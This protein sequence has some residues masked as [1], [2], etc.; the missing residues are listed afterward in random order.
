[1]AAKNRDGR[2]SARTDNSEP[3][4]TAG[5]AGGR[6]LFAASPE[7]VLVRTKVLLKIS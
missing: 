1:M 3:C 6:C 5:T 2:S 4:R 7:T